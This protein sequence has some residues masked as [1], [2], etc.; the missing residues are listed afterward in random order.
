VILFFMTVTYEFIVYFKGWDVFI[1]NFTFFCM[2]LTYTVMQTITALTLRRYARRLKIN[3]VQTTL[4]TVQIT[5]LTLGSIIFT[6][7]MV[8]VIF[9]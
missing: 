9:E 2:M 1:T 5:A 7:Q 6:V 3:K 4:F 8:L